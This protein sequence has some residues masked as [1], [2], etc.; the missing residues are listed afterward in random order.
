MGALKLNASTK[1]LHKRFLTFKSKWEKKLRSLVSL[2][3]SFPH[4]SG[5]KVRKKSRATAKSKKTRLKSARKNSF[6]EE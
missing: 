1:P 5:R 2:Q 4:G 3:G 6:F